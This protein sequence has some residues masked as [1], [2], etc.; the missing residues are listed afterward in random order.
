[1]PPLQ[2]GT[3]ER[4]ETSTPLL[5]HPRGSTGPGC[6]TP[7]LPPTLAQGAA[8]SAPWASPAPCAPL[9]ATGPPTRSSS[10]SAEPGLGGRAALAAASGKGE[11][12]SSPPRHPPPRLRQRKVPRS[13]AAGAGNGAACR[14]QT[15]RDGNHPR[16]ARVTSHPWER[17][18]RRVP[19]PP[20]AQPG[21]R[22]AGAGKHRAGSS[23]HPQTAA[24]GKSG[25]A[26][27]W[28]RLQQSGGEATH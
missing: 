3:G 7:L 5:Q 1:M 19:P 15:R 24:R 25:E 9:S 16:Q 27:P 8:A 26:R 21:G 6:R 14:R 22:R 28:V 4:R 2:Q 13:P 20:T 18:R 12:G 17:C 23:Q 10:S 11:E